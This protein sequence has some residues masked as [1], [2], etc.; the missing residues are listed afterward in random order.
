MVTT[1]KKNNSN[2]SITQ[3]PVNV[4]ISPVVLYMEVIVLLLLW[5]GLFLPIRIQIRLIIFNP[6][7]DLS[8]LL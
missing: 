1:F 4:Q 3:T 2:F 5:I 7:T 8:N 6:S